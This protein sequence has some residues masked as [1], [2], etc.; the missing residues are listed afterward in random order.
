MLKSKNIQKK[1]KITK[2][3]RNGIEISNWKKIT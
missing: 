2:E 3:N 1:E